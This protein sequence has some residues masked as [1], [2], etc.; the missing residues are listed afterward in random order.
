M[1]GEGRWRHRNS[2]T[3]SI[4]RLFFAGAYTEVDSPP[5]GAHRVAFC[6][7]DLNWLLPGR[8]GRVHEAKTKKGCKTIKGRTI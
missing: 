8:Y 7:R 1:E 5:S 6:S 2:C 4:L 3:T